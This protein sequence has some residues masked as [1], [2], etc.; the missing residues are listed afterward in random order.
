M[1]KYFTFAALCYISLKSSLKGQI[2]EKLEI[3]VTIQ[4]NIE[5]QNIAFVN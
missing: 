5:A 3:I 4:E 2:I 1:Q